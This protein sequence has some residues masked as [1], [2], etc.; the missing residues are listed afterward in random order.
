M[1]LLYWLYIVRISPNITILLELI[2]DVSGIIS[3]NLA[4]SIVPEVRFVAFKSVK[5]LPSPVKLVTEIVEGN[6]ALLSVPEDIF[7]AFRD[8]KPLPSPEIEP[9]LT[10]PVN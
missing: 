9:P 3:G 2:S 1:L 8:V 7:V 4:I 5:P 6:L 10:L